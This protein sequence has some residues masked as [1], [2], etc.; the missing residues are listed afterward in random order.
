MQDKDKT[1]TDKTGTDRSATDKYSTTTNASCSTKSKKNYYEILGL[2]Q[3]A[4]SQDIVML[5]KNY[6]PNT[7]QKRIKKTELKPNQNSMM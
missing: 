1:A 2:Q 7:I 3:N 6:Q 5:I 4:T